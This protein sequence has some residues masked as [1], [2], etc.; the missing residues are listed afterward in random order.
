M[1]K[2]D[3]HR[4]GVIYANYF[5]HTKPHSVKYKDG[6]TFYLFRLQV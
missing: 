5:T 4:S 2:S 3:L 1:T 6:L